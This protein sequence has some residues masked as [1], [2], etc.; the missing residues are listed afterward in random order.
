MSETIIDKQID[1]SDYGY[2]YKSKLEFP[3]N[4]LHAGTKFFT[5]Q[6]DGIHSWEYHQHP[7]TGELVVMHTWYEAD[8]EDDV[9]PQ[10]EVI[11]VGSKK[12]CEDLKKSK[13][14]V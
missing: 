3:E 9:M 7:E 14:Y 12:E 4:G 5:E 13:L 2:E 6:K 8:G 10:F 11:K 1:D